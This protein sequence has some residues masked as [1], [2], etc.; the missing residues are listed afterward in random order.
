MSFLP[1][2]LAWVASLVAA[3]TLDM[4]TVD[5]SCA[6]FKEYEKTTDQF[7]K[8]VIT[9]DEK[10]QSYFVSNPTGASTSEKATIL[11]TG[12]LDTQVADVIVEEVQDRSW[13]GGVLINNTLSLGA[14]VL[15]V[16]S[17]HVFVFLV[18]L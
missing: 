12:Y 4:S 6:S 14:T 7:D 9:V 15:P 16:M 2:L 18:V 11:A 8:I 5:V 3:Q 17:V 10:Y 1:L 13:S